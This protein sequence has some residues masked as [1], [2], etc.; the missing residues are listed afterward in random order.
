MR[1][2]RKRKEERRQREGEPHC[3][4]QPQPDLEREGGE[5]GVGRVGEEVVDESCSGAGLA[6][7]KEAWG[8]TGSEAG[9]VSGAFSKVEAIV[10]GGTAEEGEIEGD[11]K[12]G[13]RGRGE[14]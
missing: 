3:A 6:I 11:G 2:R 12:G 9:M 1:Q 14:K 10:T 7:G 5:L 8:V 4:L 13:T